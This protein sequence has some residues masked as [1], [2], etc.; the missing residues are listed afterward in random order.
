M[1]EVAKKDRTWLYVG[2]TFIVFWGF[3]LA[4]LNPGL[5]DQPPDLENTTPTLSADFGWVL[6]TLDGKSVSLA[7]YKGRPIVLNLWVTWCPPCRK[8]MPSLVAL[9][10]HP[11]LSK[12]AFLGV[13]TEKPTGVV[14]SYA[15][16]EMKGMTVLRSEDVPG[17]FKTDGIPATFIISPDGK[18]LVSQVGTAKWDDPSVVNLLKLLVK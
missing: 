11:E 16:D 10:A 12:V 14:K 2:L 13:T 17:V 1:T 3:Y 9:A 7:D 15:Q 18:I 8:E 6:E 5:T 4:V